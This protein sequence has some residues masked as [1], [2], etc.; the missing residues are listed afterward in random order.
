M[1]ANQAGG[2][3]APESVDHVSHPPDPH[4]TMLVILRLDRATPTISGTLGGEH[5]DERPFWGWLELST[6]LDELRGAY[7][8]GQGA[9]SAERGTEAEN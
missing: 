3:A 8:P 2:A 5:G 7:A 6:A 1:A 4:E 9:D